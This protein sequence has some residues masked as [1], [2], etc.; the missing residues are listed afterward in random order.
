MARERMVTR[1]INQ[2]TVEVL[3]LNTETCE[4]TKPEYVLGGEQ[5]PDTAMKALKKMYETAT[6]KLVQVTN[7]QSKEILVGMSEQEFIKYAKV[8]PPRTNVESKED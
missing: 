2:V 6:F 4:V 5:T 1:T 7:M 3:A 8:L